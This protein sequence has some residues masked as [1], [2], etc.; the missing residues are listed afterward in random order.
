MAGNYKGSCMTNGEV[1][2]IH[3]GM[4]ALISTWSISGTLSGSTTVDLAVL[5]GGARVIDVISINSTWN[6]SQS[7]LVNI[8]VQGNALIASATNALF[9]R[10]G[11]TGLGNRLT[12]DATV[13]MQ[14]SN[15][16]GDGPATN[17]GKVLVQYLA[18]KA[19]D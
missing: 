5:P 10:A 18:D 3:V 1:A 14:L 19:P 16:G 4:N 12:S 9:V 6:A 17:T 8:A 15:A 13:T 2:T 7:G 11:S